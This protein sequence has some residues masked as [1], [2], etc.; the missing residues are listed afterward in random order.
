[1]ILEKADVV[2]TPGSEFGEY[3]EGYFR[4]SLTVNDSRL[5]EALS[6]MVNIL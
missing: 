2:V 6:R 3:G 4:I 5:E 1:M